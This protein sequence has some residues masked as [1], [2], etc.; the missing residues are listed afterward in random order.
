[1]AKW[2]LEYSEVQTDKRNAY[3]NRTAESK[4]AAQSGQ[5]DETSFEGESQLG[6]EGQPASKKARLEPSDS[7]GNDSGERPD[8]YNREDSGAHEDDDETLGEEAEEDEDEEEHEEH[9]EVEEQ[10][11]ETEEREADDEALDNGEDSD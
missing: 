4:A 5:G 9:L 6:R 11:E 2:E 1:M 7:L 10:L 3:R 8:G